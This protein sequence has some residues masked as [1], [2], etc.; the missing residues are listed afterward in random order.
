[1][2]HTGHVVAGRRRDHDGGVLT[3]ATRDGTV[4]GPSSTPRPKQ[5]MQFSLL[6]PQEQDRLIPL[7][8]PTYDLH[9]AS[10]CCTMSVLLQRRRTTPV[11]RHLRSISIS[12]RVCPGWNQSCLIR[13]RRTEEKALFVRSP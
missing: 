1:M 2:P 8:N 3:E 6:P 4:R 7:H 9:Y 12:N 10:A 11:I 5:N 13:T